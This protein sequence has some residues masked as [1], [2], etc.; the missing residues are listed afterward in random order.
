M[1]A[2]NG[3]RASVAARL[4]RLPIGSFHRRAMRLLGY[5]FFFELGDINT[6]GFAAPAIR[7]AWGLSIS[8][9]GFITSA[10][11]IGMFLGATGAGWFS[12]RVGRKRALIVATLW[13]SGFSLLNAFAW[14][15]PAL[16]VSRLLTG[17]GLSGATVVAITYISELFP[18]AKRGSYQG[19]IMT[20]GLCGIPVTA[21]VARFLIPMGEFGWRAV[22]VW[23]SLGLLFPLFAARLEESPRWYENHG[24]FQE[25]DDVLARLEEQTR[26][27]VGALPPIIETAPISVARRAT[28]GELRRAGYMKRL[29]LFIGVW[30][31]Q[32]LGFYGFMSW[33]PT[34]L[35]AHGFSVVHS[36]ERSSAISIGAVPGAWIAA[37]ISD[38]WERKWLITGVSMVVATCGLIY[39]LSFQTATIVV[40]G[41]LVAMFIQ[42]FAPLLYAYTPECFPTSVRNM[43]TGVGYGI[44][45]LSNAFGP[46]LVAYL[47]NHY[48]YTSVFVYIA[49]CWTLVA[50]L[51]ASFGPRTKGRVLT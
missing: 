51:I 7:E 14:N 46:L 39:G 1:S 25:A 19:W 43:S 22:F 15:T 30:I 4:D 12:D 49:I 32:T 45:R 48:G 36:L 2:V 42:T 38:R 27:E 9:I 44:G 5:V 6:F 3:V 11:F 23:G 40:F 24:R 13:Y 10:T 20:I 16:L 34:L 28:F 33:V 26:S 18:A 8:T 50:I 47:F 29:I 35:A 37:K 21:Y 17:V 41:F 31:F